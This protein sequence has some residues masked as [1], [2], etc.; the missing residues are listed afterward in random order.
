MIRRNLEDVRSRIAAAALRAGRK[1]E[2]ILLVA[3]SK[4]KPVSMIE[5]AMAGGQLVFG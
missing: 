3:V 4:T 5:E 2:D 1:P